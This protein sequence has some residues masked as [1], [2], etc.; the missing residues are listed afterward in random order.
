MTKRKPTRDDVIKRHMKRSDSARA[1]DD[2][3]HAERTYKADDAVGRVEWMKAPNRV[4]IVGLDTVDILPPK[5]W[6]KPKKTTPKKKAVT[7]KKTTVAKPKKTATKKVK[8]KKS[9]SKQPKHRREYN[10]VKDYPAATKKKMDSLIDESIVNFTN[11]EIDP[12][13]DDVKFRHGLHRCAGGCAGYFA[14]MHDGSKEIGIKQKMFRSP[15]AAMHTITHELVHASRA[16][17]SD[18]KGYAKRAHNAF[19]RGNDEEEA[20]T[21]AETVARVSLK[22]LKADDMYDHPSYYTRL[23]RTEYDANRLHD[24]HILSGTASNVI[25]KKAIKTIE[26]N[27]PKTHI[28]KMAGQYNGHGIRGVNE[29]IDQHFL[30]QDKKTKQKTRLHMY[31]PKGDLKPKVA[32]Q[33]AET[34]DGIKGDDTVWAFNDGKKKLM[35]K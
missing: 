12:V 18:R 10:Y 28:A 29:N 8:S 7:K 2:S 20:Q 6:L 22:S 16:G 35:I 13:L 17:S 26:D 21:V 1:M 15:N 19:G 5:G 31:S 27:Y 23:P 33:F 25:G 11:K 9:T 32:A 14:I 3:L 34:L 30:I 24:K 4:D